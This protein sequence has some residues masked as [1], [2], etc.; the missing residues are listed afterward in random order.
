LDA[1]SE[2]PHKNNNQ[3]SCYKTGNEDDFDQVSEHL[4]EFFHESEVAG[5]MVLE[6][7]HLKQGQESLRMGKRGVVLLFPR[8]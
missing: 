5:L 4:F 1:Y 8:K 3:H 7:Y 6:L 2:R